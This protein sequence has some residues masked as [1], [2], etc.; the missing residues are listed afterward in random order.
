MRDYKKYIVWQKSHQLVLDIYKITKQYPKEEVFGL[1]SQMRRSSSSIPTNISEGAGRNS[2]KEFCRFLY[3]AFG[4][5]NE[6]E[7][8]LILSK[9][10]NYIDNEIASVLISNI[11][12]VKKMLNKLIST[13]EK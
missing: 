9:D 11:E 3:I 1:V 12:E 6:I 5:S 4:S 10:L 7:Y 13:L 8:Q 2:D